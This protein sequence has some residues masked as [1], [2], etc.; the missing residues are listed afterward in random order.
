MNLRQYIT[1]MLVGTVLCWSAWFFV[2]VNVNPFEA[3]TLS[4]LFFYIS[5]FLALLGTFSVLIFVV[6]RL[7]SRTELPL[8]RYVER[9]FRESFILSAICIFLLFLRGI[10]L[11]NIWNFS[12]FIVLLILLFSF[13]FSTRKVSTH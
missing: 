10:D 5:F 2:I 12:F 4:F 11:L 9:S 8:F 3:S 6:Y 1:I 13:S 7:F